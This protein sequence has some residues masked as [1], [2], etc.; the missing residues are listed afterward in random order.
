ML[1]YRY[2]F[3]YLCTI[4]MIYVYLCRGFGIY[5]RI[6]NACMCAY[7]YVLYKGGGVS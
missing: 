7:V 6:M 1:N 5:F 4:F 3:I 2:F